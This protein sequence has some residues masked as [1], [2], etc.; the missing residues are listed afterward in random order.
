MF[1]DLRQRRHFDDA[2]DGICDAR[3]LLS[4][5]FQLRYHAEIRTPDALTAGAHSFIFF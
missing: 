5:K 2:P 4:A 3:L 1:S